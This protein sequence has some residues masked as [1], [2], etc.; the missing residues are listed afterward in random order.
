MYSK[1]SIQKMVKEL[2]ELR[3]SNTELTNQIKSMQ[4]KISNL[5]E[6][7]L[8][9]FEENMKLKERHDHTK[10]HFH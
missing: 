1:T 8:A 7:K 6:E 10:N 4:Y 3:S 2:E 5:E 9:L